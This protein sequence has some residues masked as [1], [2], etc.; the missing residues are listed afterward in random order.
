MKYSPTS[1]LRSQC[2]IVI[3]VVYSIIS[4]ALTILLKLYNISL[5]LIWEYIPKIKLYLLKLCYICCKENPDFINKGIKSF[6]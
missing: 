1:L 5:F 4:R 2:D 3:Q 6:K